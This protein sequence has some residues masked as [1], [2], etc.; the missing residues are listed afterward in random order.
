MTLVRMNNRNW[1]PMRQGFTNH[2]DLM[3]WFWN[4]HNRAQNC[5]VNPPA[6]IIEEGD[7]F[8]IELQ[9]P[10]FAKKDINIKVE[11]RVL[12]VSAKK[13]EENTIQEDTRTI[14]REFAGDSFSRSFRISN[15]IDADGIE[16]KYNTGVLTLMVPKKEEAKA[17]PIREIQV[18]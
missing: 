11:E 9:V 8:R 12:T 15:W 3:N 17:K 13:E 7:H 2:D 5:S 14:Q 10:G 4:G 1:M 16:A 18:K 6:N